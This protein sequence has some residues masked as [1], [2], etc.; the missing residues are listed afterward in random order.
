[1]ATSSN[2]SKAAK[3]ADSTPE[4]RFRPAPDVY[5]KAISI[6]ESL[7][8]NV[9]DVARMGLTQLANQ[10]EIRLA[11]AEARPV[12]RP[13]ALR[14]YPMHG[15]TVGRIA[16]IADQA[17]R[18]ADARHAQAERAVRAPASGAVKSAAKRTPKHLRAVTAKR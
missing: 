4:I 2:A 11:P 6:A 9:N 17:A 16:E 8:L 18:A 3:P 14:D 5:A 13:P 10:R 12:E 1:M 7:G 15:V